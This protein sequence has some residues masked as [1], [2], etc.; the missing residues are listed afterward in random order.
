M[1]KKTTTAKKAT[2]RKTSTTKTKV[3][4]ADFVRSQP[5]DMPAK[6][7]IAKAKE[8]GIKL[9]EDTIYK[10]RSQDKKKAKKSGGKKAV[11]V[12][13]AKTTSR[14]DKKQRVLDLAAKHPDWSKSK[15]AETVGCTPNYVYSVLG[16]SGQGKGA[17]SRRVAGTSNG[18]SR[19]NGAVT[20]FYKAVKGVG[21]VLKAQELLATIEAFQ[22]A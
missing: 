15:I 9:T 14:G 18:H 3:T 16:E 7:L 6:D 12:A 21:G 4:K 19:S 20:A 1:P 10:T 2:A 22:N 17:V 13:S 5:S 11:P 8:A